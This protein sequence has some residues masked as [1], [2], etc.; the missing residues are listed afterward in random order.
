MAIFYSDT[1]TILNLESVC[2]TA[3]IL[4][5]I[6]RPFFPHCTQC[7]RSGDDALVFKNIWLQDNIRH[8]KST[9]ICKAVFK[10]VKCLTLYK[11][12]GCLRSD[13]ANSITVEAELK[14]KISK[15]TNICNQTGNPMILVSRRMKRSGYMKRVALCHHKC[16]FVTPKFQKTFVFNTRGI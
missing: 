12:H 1:D 4:L 6:K 5:L 13:Q 3:S 10:I 16:S 2:E 11:I 9:F 7:K 14:P 8:R 15:S